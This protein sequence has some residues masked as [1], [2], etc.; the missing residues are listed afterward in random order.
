MTKYIQ[1]HG[2]W[3]TE[4]LYDLSTDPGEMNNL[5]D[6]PA[7]RAKKVDLRN[8]LYAGLSRQDGSH[9]V[10]YT[11]R[12]NEGIVWRNADGGEAAPFPDRWLKEPNRPDRLSG[13]L[14]PPPE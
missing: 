9:V 13:L 4:E 7:W 14:P 3:D 11:E 12:I 1:Y 6:D 5:I 10:P 2:V 8:R